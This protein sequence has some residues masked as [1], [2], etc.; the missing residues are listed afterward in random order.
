[1]ETIQTQKQSL[2]NQV[3]IYSWVERV[4]MPVK[5]LAQGHSATLRQPRPEPKTSRSKVADH[6]H[7][8]TTPCMYLE[9][10]ILDIETLMVVTVRELVLSGSFIR[11]T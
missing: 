8:A 1:M 10:C 4:H 6:S 9:Y 2:S 7:R 11:S 5:C 3:L